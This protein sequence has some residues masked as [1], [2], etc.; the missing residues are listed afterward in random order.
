MTTYSIRRIGAFAVDMLLVGI[1]YTVLL[2]L[3]P[4]E[5]L[6]HDWSWRGR[7]F[8]WS[9]DLFGFL[10]GIYFVGSDLLNKHE[11][12]GKDIF[13][14]RTVDAADG[15]E[16]GYQQSL[17]RTLL[18]LVSIWMLPV[19]AFLYLWKGRGF[20]LQDFLVK[21]TVRPIKSLKSV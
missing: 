16:P 19:S 10:T 5:Q 9:F 12:P 2:N 7:S 3:I 17:A 21:T 4:E 11:T 1:A 18:K 14:L 20:T 15:A 13:H 6:A 8:G